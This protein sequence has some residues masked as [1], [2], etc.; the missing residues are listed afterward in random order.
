[1]I[2]YT[3]DVG[4]EDGQEIMLN[5]ESRSD[6]NFIICIFHQILTGR[7]NSKNEWLGM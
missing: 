5:E 3:D 2:A 6:M 4:E 7:V 1:M